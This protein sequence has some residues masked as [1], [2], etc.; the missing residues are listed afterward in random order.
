MIFSIF[1]FFCIL[2][3]QIYK[4]C[5]NHTSMESYL[6]SIQMMYICIY[7]HIS[8]NW[9]FRLVLCSSFT[10]LS[11]NLNL[12][13]T[14][15][16]DINDQSIS[17]LDAFQCLNTPY[18]QLIGVITALWIPYYPHAASVKCPEWSYLI[19]AEHPYYLQTFNRLCSFW[20][21]RAGYKWAEKLH[22]DGSDRRWTRTALLR[23][24]QLSEHTPSR[25]EIA[26]NALSVFR[27]KTNGV[28]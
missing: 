11:T 15:H 27:E 2:R 22:S 16:V 4:Y 9:H 28:Y 18:K 23:A 10:Y 14:K 21:L 7:I 5:P 13:E 25:L 24:L 6:F 12:T 19:L 20:D 8:K 17:S 26:L 3:F 1:R